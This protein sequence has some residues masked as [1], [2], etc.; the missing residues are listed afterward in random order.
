MLTVIGLIIN[1]GCFAILFPVLTRLITRK[2]I[3][4]KATAIAVVVYVVVGLLIDWS[5]VLDR[6]TL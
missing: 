3:G 4:W 1:A 6:L 5:G 2:W